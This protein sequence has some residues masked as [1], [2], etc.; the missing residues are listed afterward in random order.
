MILK[1]SVPLKKDI[2]LLS[3]QAS[4]TW[5]LICF[6]VRPGWITLCPS[7]TK[8]T[9]E[10]KSVLPGNMP[11]NITREGQKGN[12][13]HLTG[14]VDTGRS[15]EMIPIFPKAFCSSVSL[16]S[17]SLKFSSVYAAK[18]WWKELS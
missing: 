3:A 14:V 8:G 2:L 10:L 11:I 7:C 15:L 5:Q 17:S 9:E 6:F 4:D 13:K 18:T 12:K 16:V 1:N